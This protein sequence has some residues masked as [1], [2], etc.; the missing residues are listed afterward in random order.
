MRQADFWVRGQPGLQS[1][2][3]D[4]QGYTEKLCLEKKKKER[5]K[6][7]RVPLTLLHAILG[8]HPMF[9]YWAPLSLK[10]VLQLGFQVSGS[11]WA[12]L[13]QLSQ[14]LLTEASSFVLS[15]EGHQSPNHVYFTS[16]FSLE[17]S[18]HIIC[19]YTIA[20]TFLPMSG[21]WVLCFFPSVTS[22]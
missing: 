14:K 17:W 10:S 12:C 19:P 16:W 7:L 9:S 18:T 6:I 3:Q 2:F 22:T 5:K 21:L 11:N 4:S 8:S 13:G 20:L 15:S 1:E